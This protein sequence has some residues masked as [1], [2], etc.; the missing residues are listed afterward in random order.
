MTRRVSPLAAPLLA[1]AL[2]PA[3]ARAEGLI[4]IDV[5]DSGPG[6]GPRVTAACKLEAPVLQS[7]GIQ[8]VISGSASALN[9][10]VTPLPLATH[11]HCVLR[12]NYGAWGGPSGDLPG[13]VAA[14]AGPSA[15]VPFDKLGG[16][17]VCAY[18]VAFFQGGVTVS[19]LP[20]R[21]C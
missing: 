11:V 15:T 16:I 12:T 20:S 7:N 13:P 18:G 6:T 17:R 21:G 19:S 10:A 1:I 4:L 8:F 5:V 9:T 14:A 3:S 2:A